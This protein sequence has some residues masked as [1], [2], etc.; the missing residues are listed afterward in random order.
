MNIADVKRELSSDEKVLESAFRLET[1]Y[2]KYK[3]IIWAVLIGLIIFFVSSSV[4]EKM[5]ESKLKEANSAFLVLQKNPKDTMAIATLKKKNP[6]LFELFTYAQASKNKNIDS[7]TSLTK[8]KNEIISDISTYEVSV[9]KNKTH[10]S[11][12]YK[13]LVM[14]EE[15]YLAIKSGDMKSAKLKLA[16][17]D[18]RSPLAT[19]ASLLRHLVIKAK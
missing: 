6:A 9:L 15:A 13:E 12:L 1:L 4:I 17:I 5:H 11:K 16:L 2:K 19:V 3:I 18:E 14:V 10:D 7:L 8:S